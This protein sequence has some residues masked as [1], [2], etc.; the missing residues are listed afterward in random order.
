MIPLLGTGLVL[1]AGG[2]LGFAAS[3]ELRSTLIVL[4]EAADA[5]ERMRV[6]VC[7]RRMTLPETLADLSGTCPELFAG[8]KAAEKTLPDI[9]FAALWNTLVRSA[10]LSA[11]AE[12]ALLELGER[13]TSGQPPEPAFEDCLGQLGVL[14][15][16][17]ERRREQNSR[18]YVAGGFC[19]GALI[20][21]MLL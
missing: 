16:K 8:A 13:L 1:C 14:I 6:C 15:G 20:A 4:R 11:P 9:P 19:T 18:L 2:G 5:V 3:A 17:A 21:I 7:L 12:S 10:G